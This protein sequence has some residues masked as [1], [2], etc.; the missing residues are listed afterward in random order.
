[1]RKIEWPRAIETPKAL[2]EASAK[3]VH[4]LQ[5]GSLL[6]RGFMQE[7]QFQLPGDPKAQFLSQVG[8]KT[9]G[10]KAYSLWCQFCL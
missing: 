5:K 9:P 4:L 6:R 8:I 10:T 3:T 2:T 7:A 1:M